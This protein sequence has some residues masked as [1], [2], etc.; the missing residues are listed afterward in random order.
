[1]DELFARISNQKSIK[2][3]SKSLTRYAAQ[4]SGYVNDMEDNDY[5]VRSA[6]EAPFFM[7][8]LLSKL[9]SRDNAEF[10]REMKSRKEEETIPNLIMWLH[11]EAGLRSRSNY[12]ILQIIPLVH[13]VARLNTCWLRV[14]QTSTVD[15][16][17]EV[18]KKNQRCQ[19]CLRSHH[20]ME[21]K[22]ID[23]T[24]CDKC[25]KN[26]HRSLHNERKIADPQP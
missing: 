9:D 8:Q 5:S 10:G 17:W 16:R 13:L 12:L 3:D 19:K 22:K 2:S 4:I 14:P 7:S 26:H 1:M 23:G 25:K 11:K 21:C 6:S 20:T 15:Q 24:T 18:V